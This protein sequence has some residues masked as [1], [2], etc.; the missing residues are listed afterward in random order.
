MIVRGT[1]GGGRRFVAVSKERYF[2]GQSDV[3]GVASMVRFEAK[4]TIMVTILYW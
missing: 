2:P 3:P 4:R 1:R